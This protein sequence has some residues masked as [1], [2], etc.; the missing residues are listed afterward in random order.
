MKHIFNFKIL[1]LCIF[2]F[3]AGMNFTSTYAES[4]QAPQENVETLV[5]DDSAVAEQVPAKREKSTDWFSLIIAIGYLLGVFV[6]LPIVIYTNYHEKIFFANAEN[7]DKL[8]IL[9]I[10]DEEKNKIA[11]EILEKIEV[12]MSKIKGDDGADYITITS[13]KQAR[14]VKR[15][16]DYINKRLAPNDDDIKA[17]VVE[18]ADVYADRTKRVFTGSKWIIGCAIGLVVLMGIIDTSILLSSFMFLHVLGLIFYYLSSRTSLYALEKRLKYFG[19]SK[20]G[21]MGAI[22]GG[23]FAGFAAKEYVSV[24]GGPW[25]RDYEGEMS[26]S[27]A[28]ILVIVVVAMFIAFMIALFGIIN[29]VINYSTSFLLPNQ[30]E[31]KWYQEN[32]NKITT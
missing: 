5:Q 7:Q 30:N 21:F 1:I 16:L 19:S 6:L 23:L 4:A 10:K 28:L 31:E 12:K 3:F 2:L 11:T 32:F 25:Q 27:F 26:T 20:L 14:Y 29:F 24:N 9:N 15:G 22:L 8:D 17:R 18:L 13:G